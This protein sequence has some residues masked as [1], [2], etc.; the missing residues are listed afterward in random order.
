MDQSMGSNQEQSNHVTPKEKITNKY[1][2]YL[3]AGSNPLN[4]LDH[5]GDSFPIPETNLYP[6][7]SA[8]SSIRIS[9]TGHRPP[10]WEKQIISYRTVSEERSGDIFCFKHDI[11]DALENVSQ[12]FDRNSIYDEGERGECDIRTFDVPTNKFLV[13]VRGVTITIEFITNTYS[14]DDYSLALTLDYGG[15]WIQPEEQFRAATVISKS[16]PET[17]SAALSMVELLFEYD[18]VSDIPI[19]S[20]KEYSHDKNMS[21]Y[22]PLLSDSVGE[23]STQHPHSPHDQSHEN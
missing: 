16:T 13:D 4:M 12:Y 14:A 10:T 22:S 17:L 21:D 23:G 11:V 3:Y 19:C 2:L 15:S 18:P 8:L 20:S 7:S 1:E 5:A 6:P 9:Q